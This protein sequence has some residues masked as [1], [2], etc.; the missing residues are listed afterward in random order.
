VLDADDVIWLRFIAKN[1][2]TQLFS[3][4]FFL[5]ASG[6]RWLVVGATHFGAGWGNSAQEGMQRFAPHFA[7]KSKSPLLHRVAV[8]GADVGSAEDRAEKAKTFGRK[9]LLASGEGGIRTRG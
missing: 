3:L 8:N 2:P 6:S 9:S 4:C 7:P 1:L 5:C